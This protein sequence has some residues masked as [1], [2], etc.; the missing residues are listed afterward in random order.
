M[1]APVPEEIYPHL[2]KL[3]DSE[4]ARKFSISNAKAKAYRE[5]AGVPPVC[6]SCR[7][8]E[9]KGRVNECP[10]HS[11]IGKQR[12]AEEAQRVEAAIQWERDNGPT[13]AE[14]LKELKRREA[15]A[16]THADRAD[17]LLRMSLSGLTGGEGGAKD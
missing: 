16:R 7:L 2:G 17:A 1:K 4:V 5:Q 9:R 10:I 8:A 11:D 15:S 14:K 6:R 13:W 12:R 3:F